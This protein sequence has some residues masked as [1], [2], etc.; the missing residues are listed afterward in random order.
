M[1]APTWKSLNVISFSSHSFSVVFFNAWWCAFGILS[2]TFI[3][4]I[5]NKKFLVF[6]IRFYK[7]GQTITFGS[8]QTLTIGFYVSSKTSLR[9]LF[10]CLISVKRWIHVTDNN[11]IWN[12]LTL[13]KAITP[14]WDFCLKLRI[15]LCRNNF[16][17]TRARLI[18]R[19]M[20]SV[21]ISKTKM[22]KLF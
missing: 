3:I 14:I 4:E 11:R 9:F 7:I 15:W 22:A 12:I 21:F 8:L 18:F 17:P 5:N 2:Q 13:S 19:P 10:S 16:V 1:K 6:F 20:S